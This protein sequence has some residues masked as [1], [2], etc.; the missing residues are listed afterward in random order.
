MTFEGSMDR[1]NEALVEFHS[2]IASDPLIAEESR[3][4]LLAFSDEAEV[5]MHSTPAAEI[6][7]MPGLRKTDRQRCFG[8]VF[9]LLKEVI[10]RDFS[11]YREEIR[12]NPIVFLSD[13][14][15]ADS[16]WEAAHCLNRSRSWKS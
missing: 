11:L 16:D 5:L 14:E 9:D 3:I 2:A 12:W 4:S 7:H 15:P 10:D 1:F 13:G 8:P 6:T